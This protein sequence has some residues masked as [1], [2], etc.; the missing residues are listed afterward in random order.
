[1]EGKKDLTSLKKNQPLR[2]K[3]QSLRK[4]NFLVFLFIL[5][6]SWNLYEI[7]NSCT[8]GWDWDGTVTPVYFEVKAERLSRATAQVVSTYPLGITT[9]KEIIFNRIVSGH[10]RLKARTCYD[11]PCL[12]GNV[13]R[14]SEWA[15][16]TNPAQSVV[17]GTPMGWVVYFKPKPASGLKV[18]QFLN[19]SQD[20]EI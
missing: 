19:L 15:E 7:G 13:N 1:M 4:N 20:D 17:N 16:S 2:K 6:F 5:W 11:S 9:Q 8:M 3:F 10:F 18:S 12:D 14:T